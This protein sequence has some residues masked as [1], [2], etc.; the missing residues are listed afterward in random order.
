VGRSDGASVNEVRQAAT[1]LHRLA[2][3]AA[4]CL[5]RPGSIT[6]AE[7]RPQLPVASADSTNSDECSLKCSAP[8]VLELWLAAL[9]SYME[10]CIYRRQQ[11]RHAG[12]LQADAGCVV[13]LG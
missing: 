7:L 3:C 10:L 12:G 5:G 8:A 4:A 13:L 1:W 9:G 2:D 11:M 6:V